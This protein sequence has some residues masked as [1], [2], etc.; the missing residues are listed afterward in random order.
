MGSPQGGAYRWRAYGGTRPAV[1][2]PI[3]EGSGSRRAAGFPKSISEQTSLTAPIVGGV[4][5]GLRGHLT[6]NSSHGIMA[7]SA[8]TNRKAW[9]IGWTYRGE[10][11]TYKPYDGATTLFDVEH[12]GFMSPR[13]DPEVM[14]KVDKHF[15]VYDSVKA[16]IIDNMRGMDGI[17]IDD[18]DRI[19]N[20]TA[21]KPFHE[22]LFPLATKVHL[23]SVCRAFL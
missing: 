19:D 8:Y 5:P 11:A 12:A 3:P 4:K 20:R 18:R 2:T 10:Y 7:T 9:P 15:V 13:P 22:K 16:L 6:A 23:A 17:K 14:R 21:I 1:G